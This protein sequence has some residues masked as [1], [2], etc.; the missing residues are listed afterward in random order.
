[1]E[2]T[3]MRAGDHHCRDCR[4][5]DSS[6]PD[7]WSKPHVDLEDEPWEQPLPGEWGSCQR[8]HHRTSNVEWSDVAFLSDGSGYYAS[9][10][11]TAD[12]GCSLWQPKDPIGPKEEV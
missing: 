9:L 3:A 11:T 6:W 10:S 4:H 2:G 1:M 12:F 5:W 8:I 7:D